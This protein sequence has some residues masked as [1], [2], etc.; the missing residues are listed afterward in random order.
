ML[1]YNQPIDRAGQ[2]APQQRPQSGFNALELVNLLWRRKIAIAAAALL[3]ATL[4]VSVGKSVTPR[5]TATAQLYVDPR[6]LQLVDR[7]LTPRAQDVSGMAMVV[8]SQAR[9]ITSNSVLLQVIQQANLDKDPEFGGGGDARSLMSSLLG[10]IGLQPRA[11]SAAETKEVQLAALDALN[12]HITVR[13]TEKSFIVDIEVW[14]TDPAKAA[15][16]ANT[17]TSAYLAES[18][19]SQASAARRA[20]NDLSGRLKELRERLRSAETALATYKAQNN[21]V[22]TQDAL[23]SDQQLSASNQRLSAARA[24]TMDAQARLDQ[25]EASRRTAAD[26]GANSEALQSPTIANLRAQYADARKKYA[27]QAGELGPRH[28]ALRQTEKQVEDLKRTINEEIDRFAQSA[29]NDL[30]RARDFEASLN[31][32]LEAQKRQSVQLSQAA[33]RLRELEREADASRDVY[34]SFLKRSR[35]TEEQET[36]NTS[37]ARVIGEATVPQRRS[38]PPAMSMFAMIGF[39]FGAL[40]AASWFVAAELLST[41]ATAPAAPTPARRE[42]TPAPRAPRAPE[43]SRTPEIAQPQPAPRVPEVAQSLPELAAPSLQPEMDEDTLIGKPLI[44]RLQEADVI[45]TLG[46][47]LATGGGVDLT[48]LGWPTLRPGFPLTTLLNTWRDM[49]TAVARRAG[50]KAMPVIALVGAGETTGRSVTALNFA[51]AAARDGA[52][53]LMIDADHQ[54][55]SLSNKVSRPGKSEPSRLGWLSIGSKAAREIKTVNGISVLPAADGDAGK[56]TEAMRKA[57]EQARAAGGYDLVILDGPVTPLGAASRKLLDDADALVAVLPTS[58]DI[59]DG[60]EE[61][62]NTL[63]R[64]ER[65]LVGVVL[66]ELTPATQARQRGR[67]YA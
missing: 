62:L 13:K 61:I 1:D 51:L 36:L 65:K 67:Q 20:T 11:P 57:I 8:E 25:I 17:L 30:T 59:N 60:L 49:R 40:A 39:I 9:L 48:R 50:G 35:E 45:H 7:E 34:Q 38:F 4:A 6:E 63:G 55:H 42:R 22:G 32:A 43:V 33:V 31:R 28:P 16:L 15:M 26:A 12:R 66:D 29:K 23:I 53:V 10:L 14:S 58:L 52:R 3:G 19:N 47:I 37:A 18:R 41:G 2:E 24:A 54:A 46:A 64:A 5:Y 44:A 27:E 56:A 21:F